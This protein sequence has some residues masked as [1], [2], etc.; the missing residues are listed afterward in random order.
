MRIR[1]R[2]DVSGT[3]NGR[4][5]PR[6]GQVAEVPDAEGAKLCAVG[7]A[8][9]VAERKQAETTVAPAAEK[10]ERP[11]PEKTEKPAAEKRGRGRPRLPRDSEG[12]VVKE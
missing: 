3:R 12:N 8:E 7:L 5:W 1:M 6:R 10:S 9:P 2:V 4:R 11:D